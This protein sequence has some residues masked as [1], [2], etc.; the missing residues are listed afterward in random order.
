M[1][2]ATPTTTTMRPFALK[3]AIAFTRLWVVGADPARPNWRQ[4]GLLQKLCTASA[5]LVVWAF[6][7][8]DKD[9]YEDDADI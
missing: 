8:G 1:A 3:H 2:T 7:Y 6:T 4:S 5:K 9:D